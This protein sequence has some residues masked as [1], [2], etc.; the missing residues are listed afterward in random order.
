MG[1]SGAAVTPD[2][3]AEEANPTCRL[4]ETGAAR[5]DSLSIQKWLPLGRLTQRPAHLLDGLLALQTVA[6]C[7]GD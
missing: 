7:R 6:G 3:A 1:R 2:L 5:W 4:D